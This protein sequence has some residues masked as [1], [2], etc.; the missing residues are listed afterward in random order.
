MEHT[1]ENNE[2]IETQVVANAGIAGAENNQESQENQEQTP[3]SWQEQAIAFAKENGREVSD[4]NELLKPV[5]VEKEVIKEVNPYEKF[6]TEEDKSFFKYAEETGRT[7]KEFD[8]LKV[9]IESI[10]PLEIAREQARRDIGVSELDPEMADQYIAEQLG[11]DLEDLSGYD[12]VKLLGY[13]KKIR[14]EK[15]SQQEQYRTKPVENKTEPAQTISDEYIP[16]PNGAVMRKSDYEAA[17]IAQQKEL[18][19]AVQAVKTVR[20]ATFKMPV[21]DNGVVSEVEI[22]Y[23][24]SDNDVQNM[25]SIVSD[26]SGTI[27]KRY[28][29]ENGFNHAAF[30]EDMQWSDRSFREKAIADIATKIR[31]KAIEETMQ[32][33]GNHNFKPH[34][35]LHK[36][37]KG[38]VKIVSPAEAFGFKNHY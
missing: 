11:I 35:D 16:L 13:G 1:G 26:I 38:G 36:Q 33:N 20:A 4:F 3:I 25:T 17:Q 8:A 27:A 22:P 31:A 30:G 18:E 6:I 37:V 15:K 32:A 7:R 12:R 28:N 24:Y 5:E 10:D 29:S 23:E 14:D 2:N 21:D 19:V 34:K 9:D